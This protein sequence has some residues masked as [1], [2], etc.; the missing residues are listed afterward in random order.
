LAK[1]EL[2]TVAVEDLDRMI[3]THSLPADT[4]QRVK[5]AVAVLE[6]FPRI[7]RQLESHW[8]PMR[9]ILGPWRWMLIVY[10]YQEA[11]DVVFVVTILDARSSTAATAAPPRT[12]RGSRSRSRADRVTFHIEDAWAEMAVDLAAGK[13]T[14][15]DYDNFLAIA[16]FCHRRDAFQMVTELRPQKVPEITTGD[17][18]QHGCLGRLPIAFGSNTTGWWARL[19]DLAVVADIPEAALA[20]EWDQR[21]ADPNTPVDSIEW[22]TEDGGKVVYRLFGGIA[23]LVATLNLAPRREEF[24]ARLSPELRQQLAAFGY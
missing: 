18:V 9:F 12:S 23:A 8:R 11:G 1:V 22:V 20:E 3:L 14:R 16:E 6:Q 2:S 21:Q 13:I 4:R 15:A 17:D 24:R 5:R 10:T 7:G 19:E